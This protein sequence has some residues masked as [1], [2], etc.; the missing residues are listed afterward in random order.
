MDVVLGVSMAPETVRMVLVE[1]EAAGGVTVDQDGFHLSDRTTAV[2]AADRV[3]AAILGTRESAAQGGH[4][5]KSSGV[6]WSDPV[7]A[8]ALRNALAAR[9]IE[10]VMLVSSVMAAAALAQ[11]AGSATNCA[12]TA[13]L[14]VEPTTATLAVVDTADGSVADVRR[15]LL[16]SSDEAA[17]AKLASMVSGAESMRARPDGLFLVGSDVDIPF[18]KPALEAATSL[19]V[20]TPEEPEM[21][22]AR[23]ASL[24]AANAQLGAPSTIAMPYAG[25]PSA[26]GR[27]LA[28][29]AE[30]DSAAARATRA[31]RESAAHSGEHRSRKSVLAVIAAT[32]VFVGGVVAL[33]LALALDIRPH[34][35][36]RP[37]ITQ[38][39]V[40]P[41]VQEP[42][43]PASI[44]P[45]PASAPPAPVSPQPGP[46]PSHGEQWDDWL[47]RHLGQHGIPI[48]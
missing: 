48:P 12:R 40:A 5:L 7:E 41:S 34:A 37:D 47:H 29:S 8:A 11:A 21:A 22:L 42:P 14:F 24:A 35:H 32:L 39:V 45:P 9:K 26:D 23:G 4:Q 19:S 13:L 16:P 44:P 17:L 36:Q 10:N 43:P 28:Y 30:A 31:D 38:N 6:T 15:H 2:A 3:V 27:E 20:T 18:I 1:G 46:G 33:A 25:D